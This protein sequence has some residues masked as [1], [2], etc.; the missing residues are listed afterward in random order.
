VR[1]RRAATDRCAAEKFNE[2]SPPHA[3]PDLRLCDYNIRYPATL[4]QLLHRNASICAGA[5][6][7]TDRSGDATMRFLLRTQLRRV[8]LLLV[9]GYVVDLLP[10]RVDAL[11]REYQSFA[12]R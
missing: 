2:L 1:R 4:K 11:S 6:A 12:I 10:A 8:L 9:N 3:T 5:I 7:P